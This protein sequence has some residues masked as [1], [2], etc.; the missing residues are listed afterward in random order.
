MNRRRDEGAIAVIVAICT[1]LLFTMAAFAVDFGATYNTKRQLSIAADAASL[2]AAR[3]LATVPGTCASVV[4][5][6][7]AIAAAQTAADDINSRNAPGSTPRDIDTSCIE[8]GKTMLV[9]YG[10]DQGTKTS[11]ASIIGIDQIPTAGHA[12]SAVQVAKSAGLVP[13]AI[14]L[15]DIPLADINTPGGGPIRT[16]YFPSDAT[17]PLTPNCPSSNGGTKSAKGNWYTIDC[18]GVD[19]N[20]TGNVNQPGSLAYNTKNGCAEGI[21]VIEVPDGQDLTAYLLSYCSTIAPDD[22]SRCLTANTGNLASGNLQ[23]AWD[24]LIGKDDGIAKEVTFPV[25]DPNAY[26]PAGGNGRVYPVKA[27]VGVQVC[28]YRWQNNTKSGL[29]P[30]PD[31]AGAAHPTSPAQSDW[32]LLRFKQLVVT[33][34][35]GGGC[36][37]GTSCDLGARYVGLVE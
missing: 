6:P 15:P 29:S 12:A 25:F 26:I 11:L 19:N 24:Y 35:S 14:C 36:K 20:A 27:L 21:N 37:I 32:L 17:N 7:A 28:G 30:D 8:D 3:S 5:N 4:S 22:D 18:P 16:I 9:S 10:N 1:V 23:T 2:A 34:G 31:C 13:Y 33:G